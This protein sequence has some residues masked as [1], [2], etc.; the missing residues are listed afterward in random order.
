MKRDQELPSTDSV[1]RCLQHPGLGQAKTRFLMWVE[2]T[3][4]S[5]AATK[6]QVSRKFELGVEPDLNPG[7]PMWGTGIPT[8]RNCT[9]LHSHLQYVIFPILVY[10]SVLLLPS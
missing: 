1:P 9:V 4:E 6:V 3:I 5:S 10:F 2:E 7:T 8:L